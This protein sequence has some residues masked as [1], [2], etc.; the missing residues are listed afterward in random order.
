VVESHDTL[1]FAPNLGENTGVHSN[2]HEETIDP[3]TVFTDFAALTAQGHENGVYLTAHDAIDAM[4][5]TATLNA[6]QAHH[7]LV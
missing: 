4:H 5:H 3:K 1:L 2:I 6:Q 7:F